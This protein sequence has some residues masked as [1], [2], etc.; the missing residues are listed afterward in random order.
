MEMEI[1]MPI[2]LKAMLWRLAYV[3]IVIIVLA[4]VWDPLLA[5][6]GLS[7][8]ERIFALL[9]A[10]LGIIALLYILFGPENPAPW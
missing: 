2:R 8:P 9:K 3:L 7:I 5:A 4:L 6:L 1:Y 10:V